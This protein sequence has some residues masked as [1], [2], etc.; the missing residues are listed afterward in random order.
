MFSAGLS[1]DKAKIRKLDR[2]AAV[3]DGDVFR[4]EI[5]DVL[6]FLIVNDEIESDFIGV[7]DNRW[8]LTLL[9]W[10]SLSEAMRDKEYECK[11][12]RHPD[13]IHKEFTL[14]MSLIIGTAKYA[15]LHLFRVPIRGLGH[16]NRGDDY[17]L[18]WPP[19]QLGNG[20]PGFTTRIW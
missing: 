7:A 20:S 5:E 9:S 19:V 10:R 6:V 16:A 4:F 11:Q 15:I 1:G 13:L 12:R 18:F 17:V 2:G 8:T 3:G 14:R